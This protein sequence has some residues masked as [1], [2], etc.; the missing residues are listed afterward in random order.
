MAEMLED[1]ADRM[2]QDVTIVTLMLMLTHLSLM[3]IDL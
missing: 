1:V 2:V 3:R